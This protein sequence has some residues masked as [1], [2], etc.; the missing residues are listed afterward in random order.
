MS[1]GYFGI[2]KSVKFCVYKVKDILS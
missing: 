1:R 2:F